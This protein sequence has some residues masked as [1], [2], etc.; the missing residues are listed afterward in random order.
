MRP[1]GIF[2]HQQS[3]PAMRVA[4]FTLVEPSSAV[5]NRDPA[6]GHCEMNKPAYDILVKPNWTCKHEEKSQRY[7][8]LAAIGF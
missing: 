1:G 4:K 3:E 7:P 8:L 5:V 2:L 6:L